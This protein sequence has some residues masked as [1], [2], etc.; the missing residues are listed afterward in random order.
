MG[1][2]YTFA[3]AR[4][5]G[6][7]RNLINKEKMLVMI[8]ARTMEDACKVL[9]EA[10]YGEG[11]VILPSAYEKALEA[12]TEKL[13][14]F[15]HS[16]APDSEE[17]NIFRYPFDYHNIKTILKAEFLGTSGREILMSGGSVPADTMA[18]LVKERNY[19]ALTSR[20]RAAIETS[21][22][23]HART[24][25]PQS[26]DLICDKYCYEDISETA[27]ASGNEFVKGYVRLLI[28]T[29]NLKTFTR[30]RRMNQPWSFFGDVFIPGGNISEK[31]FIAGYEENLT[32]FAS[33]LSGYALFEA[34]DGGSA[35]LK[36]TGGFT[37]LEKLCDDALIRYVKDAKYISFGIEPL[38]AYVAA[39]QMEIKSVRIILAGKKAGISE[40][41]LRERVR[42]TYG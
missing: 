2:D 11:E 35:E 34:A 23:T 16:I 1:T 12:E 15:I 28:D 8:D 36:E 7:E 22:D 31:V 3:C 4:V 5:R 10:G 32:Q 27:A 20:M 39:K 41:L 13:Y 26:V 19:M 40:G 14:E 25:D 17:F 37:S 38:I 29:I 42:E 30:V 33:R 24:K 6:N 21:L 18:V 9:Q